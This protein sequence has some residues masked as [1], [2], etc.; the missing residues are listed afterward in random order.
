MSE[1]RVLVVDDDADVRKSVRLILSKAGYDVVEAEDGEAGVRTIKRVDNPFFSLGAIICD[2]N[3]PKMSGMEA[4]PYFRS[5]FPHASVIVLSGEVTTERARV[6]SK[7]GVSDI[8]SKPI[9]QDQL[10]EAVKKVFD[11]GGWKDDIAT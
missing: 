2:L 7:Q 8:L 9:N 3:M 6:L 5:H 4:I 11:A 10:L 1:G